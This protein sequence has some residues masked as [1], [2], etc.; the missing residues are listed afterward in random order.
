VV[1]EWS[2]RDEF[3]SSA[4]TNDGDFF[5]VPKINAEEL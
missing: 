5:K 3:K 2:G 1:G 4:P